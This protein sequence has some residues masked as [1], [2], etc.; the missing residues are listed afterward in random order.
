MGL[1]AIILLLSGVIDA[2]RAQ[3]SRMS[4]DPLMPLSKAQDALVGPLAMVTILTSDMAQTKAFYS[5]ALDMTMTHEVVRGRKA[6]AL[7]RSYRL[8]PQASFEVAVFERLGIA[9]ATR[10]RAIHV[11][12]TLPAARPDH[13]AQYL[14]PLSLGFP[15][16]GIEGR[17]DRLAK[18]GNP[19]TAGVT[20]LAL[21]RTDG[22]SY[23]VKEAHFKGPDG[24]LSLGIDRADMTPVGPIELQRQIGGPAYSGIVVSDT[25]RMNTFLGDVLGFE[26]RRDVE[27]SSSG[28]N[29][30]LGLPAGTR[31]TFQQW[32]APGSATGYLVVMKYLNAGK[33]GLQALGGASYGLVR[34]SFTTPNLDRVLDRAVA[35]NIMVVQTAQTQPEIGF[36]RV[37]SA[38]LSSPD[39][40]AF[41]IIERAE[42]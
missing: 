9:Q 31:F 39:G 21:K 13:D 15:V 19:A 41:E 42:Q 3:P 4:T 8:P 32:F 17:A 36:G 33:T 10:I 24:V 28:P 18:A 35:H 12:S 20:I 11:V 26:K 6:R 2:A 30:G 34:Y 40:I 29:G 7:A 22:T 16:Q 37:R 1:L 23:E 14:G 25:A 5:D 27:L 38:V